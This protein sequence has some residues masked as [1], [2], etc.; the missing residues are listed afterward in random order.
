MIR[1]AFK[2]IGAVYPLYLAVLAYGLICFLA[3]VFVMERVA[4][5]V[6]VSAIKAHHHG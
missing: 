6:A 4:E 3:G 1:A 2:K 5:Q